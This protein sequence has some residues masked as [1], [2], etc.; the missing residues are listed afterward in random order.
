MKS[1]VTLACVLLTAAFNLPSASLA[2]APAPMSPQEDYAKRLRAAELVSPLKSDLFGDSVSLFNGAT[3]FAVTDIDIPGNGALP[4]Q[5]RRRLVVESRKEVSRLGGFGVMWDLDV[6]YMHGV[7]DH[8]FKWN[9]GGS[10]H[11]NRCSQLW[12]PQVTS[13]LNLREIWSGTQMYIPG[14]GD[15]ELLHLATTSHPVPTSGG[16]HPWTTRDGY[17]LSCK[18]TTANGYPGRGSSPSVLTA[19]STRSMSA[20]SAFRTPCR[21]EV[22]RSPASKSSS[23][24]AGWR[25][26]MAT[27]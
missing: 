22:H 3:E 2:Q 15:R 24:R 8:T 4:V 7:F 13:P 26:A 5:L 23:W 9:L 11:S 21:R 10:G 14:E 17:R 16:P 12:Y 27:G 19:R 25:I 1:S 18:A 6:P 20:S